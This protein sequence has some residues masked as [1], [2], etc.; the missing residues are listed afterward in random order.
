M[1]FVAR[2]GFPKRAT[3][4]LHRLGKPS[5]LELVR[6]GPDLF[7]RAPFCSN[8]GQTPY[9]VCPDGLSL[10][11]TRKKVNYKISLNKEVE[12]SIRLQ[13]F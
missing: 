8:C 11:L 1:P 5:F 13:T 3:G 9:P 4:S 12:I 2:L 10:F 6:M 7:F